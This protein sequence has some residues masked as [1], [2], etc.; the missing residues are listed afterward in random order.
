MSNAIHIAVYNIATSFASLYITPNS[1]I[2]FNIQYLQYVV[3]T[4]T[5]APSVRLVDLT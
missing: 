1:I 5:L 4:N 2:V 3:S